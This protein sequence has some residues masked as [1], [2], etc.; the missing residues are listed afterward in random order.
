VKNKVNQWFQMIERLRRSKT[1]WSEEELPVELIQT[2]ISLLLLGKSRVLKLK[3]PVDFGFLDYTTLEKRRIACDRE[4]ELNSR[5]CPRIYLGTQPVVEENG[6]FR[7]SGEGNI[8]DYGVLMKRLPEDRMLDRIVFDGNVTEAMISRIAEK[9]SAFHKAAR[10]GEDVNAFG[11]LETIRYN[12]EENFQQTKPYIDRTIAASD[13][14]LIR[15]WIGNWLDENEVLLNERVAKGHICDG[16]GDLRCE[17]I[18]V[19][20]G[21]CIFDCIEFND[22]FRCADVANEAAFLAMDLAANGRPDLGYFFYE[23][24]SELAGD[25][26]LFKLFSFYRCYRAF[27]RGKVLSFQL[28]EPELSDGQHISARKRAEDYFRIAASSAK[29]LQKPTMIMVS[30]LSG[31]GKTSVARSIAG[32]LGLRVVSSDAIRKSLFAE[33]GNSTEYG[34]GIYSEDS[35]RFVYQKM[36][37]KA[38]E[39]FQK[40]GSLILDATFQNAVDRKLVIQTAESLGAQIRTIEC[41]L[42][43]ESVHQRL[44]LRAE[45]KDGLSDATWETYK[46]QLS[47]HESFEIGGDAKEFARKLPRSR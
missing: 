9:I 40:D 45:R 42:D 26:Q 13:F 37:E 2:H 4:V 35:R 20:N 21:I 33:G 30:G 27:V 11:N 8:V 23:R 47:D 1:I 38:V 29:Q 36:I 19:T 18:C 3:K 46:R 43:P 12:W 41:Q 24:Y 5:L 17:S 28:D 32:E 22:R 15:A 44:K 25:E 10:R 6:T 7:F 31:T 16:H 39:I 14:E 34:K